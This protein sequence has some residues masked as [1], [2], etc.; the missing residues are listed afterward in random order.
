MKWELILLDLDGTLMD[1]APGIIASVRHAYQ[2]LEIPEPSAQT[3][4]AFVGPPLQMSIQKHGVRADQVDDFMAAYRQAFTAGGMYNNSVY[5]G[6]TDCLA[7]LRAA[8]ARLGGATS[9]PEIYAQQICDR[10]ELSPLV[11]YVFG[12]S[13]D[14]SRV[15]KAK[16]IAHALTTI[17][18]TNAGLPER[19]KI[20]MVGDR[21]HDALGAREHQIDTVGVSWGYALPGE[22]VAA[23]VVAT[24]DTP[25][26]LADHL[27]A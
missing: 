21:E 12:A 17:E 9:K 8:W 22:L 16:V 20:I 19:A 24:V 27:G 11:D 2:T 1:S 15:T 7:R 10:F 25:G 13:L 4:A 6:I 5:A 26:A 3:L 14:S 23:G 18:H